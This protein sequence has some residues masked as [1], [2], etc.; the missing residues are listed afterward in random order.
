MAIDRLRPRFHFSAPTAYLNDPNGLIQIGDV[1]HLFYQYSPKTIPEGSYKDWGHA[2]S[3]D[4]VTWEDREIGLRPRH[5]K[6]DSIGCWS[7][8]AI[9]IGTEIRLYY[10]GI[11]ANQAQQLCLARGDLALERIITNPEPLIVEGRPSPENFRTFRDPFVWREG[12]RWRALIGGAAP[13]EASPDGI[14]EMSSAD[15]LTWKVT[16]QKLIMHHEPRWWVECPNRF[17]LDGREV[18]LCSAQPLWTPLYL[19]GGKD[20]V[21]S[22]KDLRLLTSSSRFYA[23]LTFEDNKG[24]RIMFAYC[25]EART[26]EISETAGWCNVLSL[27]I[28]LS[29][30]GDQLACRPLEDLTKLRSSSPAFHEGLSLQETPVELKRIGGNQC[31]IEFD[32]DLGDAD[33][34]ILDVLAD[35]AGKEFTRIEVDAHTG[36]LFIDNSHSSL[37][38]STLNQGGNDRQGPVK[39]DWNHLP[40]SKRLTLRVFVD[41]SIVDVFTN[42]GAFATQRAYPSLAESIGVRISAKGAGARLIQAKAWTMGEIVSRA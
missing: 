4:L 33:K 14:L 39:T 23:P 5:S 11:D 29:L 21:Y 1:Y 28:E 34:I 27:P 35:P 2:V 38:S 41:R 8:C 3:R 17:M 22:S 12:D 19:V 42:G 7:G 37:D 36:G 16:R 6:S 24:R 18:L 15:G 9:E 40:S 10:T 25:E 31:E 32:F 13:D 26:P 20:E 30:T